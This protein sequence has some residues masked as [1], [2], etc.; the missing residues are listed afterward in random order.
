MGDAI[1]R[2]FANYNLRFHVFLSKSPNRETYFSSQSLEYFKKSRQ[3]YVGM[4]ILNARNIAFLCADF[5][6]QLF[7]RH[8]RFQSFC[9]QSF[10]YDKGFAS[11]LEFISFGGSYSTK[12]FG[13]QVFYRSTSI[14]L[15]LSSSFVLLSFSFCTKNPHPL[16]A[17]FASCLWVDW[18]TQTKQTIYCVILYKDYEACTSSSALL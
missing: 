11:S 10:T 9:F 8:A 2:H 1:W 3:L 14:N 18:G 15:Y 13:D 16:S 7:L 5:S 17:T 6:S 4:S 12:I